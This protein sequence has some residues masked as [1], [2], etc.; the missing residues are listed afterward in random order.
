MSDVLLIKIIVAAAAWTFGWI[1]Y[2]S[3]TGSDPHIKNIAIVFA[4]W[5]IMF[6]YFMFFWWP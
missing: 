3:T 4:P 5:I 6:V 1:G 2:F